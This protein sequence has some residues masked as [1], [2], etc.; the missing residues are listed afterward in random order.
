MRKLQQEG[1]RMAQR[2]ALEEHQRDVA[3]WNENFPEN[4][5]VLIAKRLR[6]FLDTSADVDFSAKLVPSGDKMKFADAKYEQKSS[7]WKM[8][9][10]AGRDA[11]T[12]AR[13]VAA[14]WLKELAG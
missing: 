4:P 12:A 11:V 10:R 8:C 14:A 13:A 1:A 7:E 6:A 3:K 9:Y 5:N 2:S